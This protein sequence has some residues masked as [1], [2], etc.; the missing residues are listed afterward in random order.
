VSKKISH[1]LFSILE[2][3]R[4]NVGRIPNTMSVS[5]RRLC[6]FSD[7]KRWSNIANFSPDWE[8]RTA[9]IAELI[10]PD[11][12]VLE[13]GCGRMKLVKYLP[14]GCTYIPSDIIS[15]G[16]GTLVCDLN[17]RHLPTFPTVDVIVFSGVLEYINDVPRLISRLKNSCSTIIASY[18]L[19]TN[20]GVFD[21]MQRRNVGWVNSYNE[22]DL[23]QIFQRNGFSSVKRTLWQDQAIFKV[24]FDRP[25]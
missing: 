2:P 17:A 7:I 12:K 24:E 19:A 5:L 20:R 13:F 9:L 25:K 8:T 4:L 15:R 1:Y 23:I 10:L 21:I 16:P 22:E 14:L 18:A 11:S 6:G 3:V